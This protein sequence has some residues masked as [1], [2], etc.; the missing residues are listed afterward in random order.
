MYYANIAQ[1]IFILPGRLRIC[2]RGLKGNNNFAKNI[3]HYLS[4]IA[5]ITKV[6]T[7]HYTGNVLVL[8]SE[9][10]IKISSIENIIYEIKSKM[11]SSSL[12]SEQSSKILPFPK[13]NLSIK[14]TPILGI[15]ACSGL[16]AYWVVNKS[17]PLSRK[18]GMLPLAISLFAG[19]PILR[20]GVGI[21]KQ[22]RRVNY[23]LILGLTALIGIFINQSAFGLLA[24]LTAYATGFVEELVNRKAAIRIAND[25]INEQLELEKAINSVYRKLIPIVFAVS[26]FLFISSGNLLIPLSVL[27]LM[28]PYIIYPS[29]LV[30]LRTAAANAYSNGIII[31]NQSKLELVGKVD[32]IVFDNTGLLT[33]GKCKVANIIPTGRNSKNRI[34]MLAAS[35]GQNIEDPIAKALVEEAANRNLEH[36]YASNTRVCMERGISCII[37]NKDFNIGNKKQFTGKKLF[38]GSNLTNE[39]RL[40][41]LGQ[42]PVF[43]AYNHKI[44]GVIGFLYAINENCIP[45]IEAIRETG[46]ENIKILSEENEEIVKTIALE[47]GIDD[48]DANLQYES[49]TEKIAELKKQGRTIALVNQGLND[50]QPIQNA[51]ISITI[52]KTGSEPIYKCSDFVITNSDI[53]SIPQIIDQSKYIREVLSQNYIISLGVDAIGVILVLTSSITPYSALLYKFLNSIIVLLNARKPT[54]YKINH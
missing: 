12:E 30:T 25:P 53:R 19:Y 16:L 6:T 46:I 21:L 2:I 41:H 49:K 28:F 13:D 24:L 27:V 54:K 11:N 20:K 44:I 17:F 51:D 48:Y 50:C 39:R 37:D 26:A 36:K 31:N 18:N 52:L 23:H 32:T 33:S 15:M 47:V 45:A 22:T 1:N 4:G 8:F 35:C 43:V 42:Y 5:G 34:L 29:I 40:K 9:E 7:N 3:D 14:S 38:T 10:H